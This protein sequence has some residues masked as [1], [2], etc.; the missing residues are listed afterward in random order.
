MEP[1][2]AAAHPEIATYAG[3]SLDHDGTT[4]ALDVT[5]MGMHAAV[6]GPEGQRAWYVDPAYDRPGTRCT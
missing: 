1:K 5:P 2:L 3:R 6:R 4:I